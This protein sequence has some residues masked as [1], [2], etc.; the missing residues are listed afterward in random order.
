M[1]DPSSEINPLDQLAE[2]FV[3]RYRRGERPPLSEY[4]ARRPDLADEIRDLFPGLVLME[5][6]RPE[7]GEATGAFGVAGGVSKCPE[8]LGDYRILREVGR[9]GMGIVYEAEQES[10]GRHVA[11]KV[12]PPHALN[13]PQRLERFRREARAAGR[14]HHTNI[15]PVFG[16]GEWRAG[17][18][19]PPVHYYAMQF[20]QG[21]SL[22]DVLVEVR[23]L[24][25]PATP[26]AAE[27]AEDESKAKGCPASAALA[28]SL[29]DGGFAA[30]VAELVR[31]RLPEP[32]TTPAPAVSAKAASTSS[33]AHAL[34]ERSTLSERGA[35]YWRSVARIGAQAADALAYAHAQ[36]ILHR[37]IKPSNLM[38]DNQG[39]VWI[40]DFGLAKALTD[41]DDLT[42][43]GDIVGTL[44]YMAPERF[45]GRADSRGDQY[46]LALT[47]YELLTLQPAFAAS[48]RTQLIHRVMHGEPARP[49]SLDRSIPR[50]LE[51]IVLK[52]ADKDPERRYQSAAEMADDLRR[53]A[54]D[55]PIRARRAGYGER[56]WRW[57][58]RNPLPAGLAA[59]VTISLL[60]GSIVSSWLAVRAIESAEV[61]DAKAREAGDEAKRANDEKERADTKAKEEAK[62]RADEAVARKK[63]DDALRE[64][65][66]SLALLN[67]R[68][69]LHSYEQHN[70]HEARDR[71]AVIPAELRGWEWRYLRRLCDGGL[72]TLVG[73][74]NGIQQVVYSPDGRFLA[75]TSSAEV[76]VWNARTGQELYTLQGNERP[77]SPVTFR[78]DGLRLAA[79]C[80]DGSLR[81]WDAATGR[82]ALAFVVAAGIQ[83]EPAVS[84]DGRRIAAGCLDKA[85]RVWDA[86]TGKQEFVLK[87]HEQ[88]L[89]GLAFS[90]NGQELLSRAGIPAKFSLSNWPEA[91]SAIDFRGYPRPGELKLW[92]LRTSK[93]VISIANPQRPPLGAFT[94]DGRHLITVDHARTVTVW[95]VNSGQVVKRQKL[96]YGPD[97][98]FMGFSPDRRLLMSQNNQGQLIVWDIAAGQAI[99][100]L[101]GHTE[102]IHC[103]AFSPDSMYFATGSS[104]RT[105]RLWDLRSEKEFLTLHGHTNSIGSLAFSPD[106]QQLASG[107]GDST[108]KVWDA[109][110]QPGRYH[111]GGDYWAADSAISPDGHRLM[112]GGGSGSSGVRLLDAREGRTVFSANRQYTFPSG[113]AYS[114]DGFYVASTS[115]SEAV[116]WDTRTGREF[117][118]FQHPAD[119]FPIIGSLQT[120]NGP[121]VTEVPK[122]VH[123]VAFS[124]DGK[125]LASG[126]DTWVAKG[127][128][129]GEI[130]VWDLA[131]G[132]QLFILLG[133]N[134]VERLA[135]SPDGKYLA[136][137]GGDVWNLATRNK[138]FTMPWQDCVAFSPDGRWL[139]SGRKFERAVTLWDARTGQKVWTSHGHL[140]IGAGVA[141]SPD[142]LRLFSAGPALA[143]IDG[144][145]TV[146]DVHTGDELLSFPMKGNSAPYHAPVS[147]TRD[148]RAIALGQYI[149]EAPKV[150]EPLVV[151]LHSDPVTGIAFSADGARLAIGTNNG[152]VGVYD[153]RTGEK[154]VAWGV[155][156]KAVRW[157]A[158]SP[159]GTLLA[160]SSWDI[161]VRIWDSQT[162]KELRT[163]PTHGC[164]AF[165]R[166]GARL[167]CISGGRALIWDVASGRELKTFK[168]PPEPPVIRVAFS[169]DGRRLVAVLL[170]GQAAAWNLQTGQQLPGTPDGSDL[171]PDPYFSPDGKR[172]ARPD[173]GR[174]VIHDLKEPDAD[175][176]AW[177]HSRTTFDPGWHDH[178]ATAIY[179]KTTGWYGSMLWHLDRLLAEQPDDP[180]LRERRGN[181]LAELGRW[182]EARADFGFVVRKT[183]D[184]MGAWRSLALAHLGEGKT[185]AFQETCGQLKA[186]FGRPPWSSQLGLAFT[187]APGNVLNKLVL[188]A[189]IR[190]N[191][192][193]TSYS[194]AEILR[195]CMLRPG[196][197][198][199]P[200]AL[201]AFLQPHQNLERGAVLCRA[202][203]HADAARLLAEHNKKRNPDRDWA[204]AELYLAIAEQAQGHTEEATRALE[205]AAKWIDSPNGK[206][207]RWDTRVELQT[208]RHEAETLLHDEPKTPKK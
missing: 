144:G 1:S 173:G 86:K 175:E 101:A 191:L 23:R 128:R 36:G 73:H 49:R 9:G 189:S 107:S 115:G 140:G 203:K 41:G 204:L 58:R 114:P 106:G 194:Q 123:C 6:I 161:T 61:A 53:F 153:V 82:V 93:A 206:A 146:L 184:N 148:G 202:G 28:R 124:P 78:P 160:S 156:R 110:N 12:L 181:A 133:G 199:D 22:S 51:T 131:T 67:F 186:R 8:H 151:N 64:T 21:Q 32:V 98:Y 183:P 42:R 205:K 163:F 200:A 159:D 44:R 109:R 121:V 2:E 99:Q 143:G 134:M 68:Q 92:D 10:L 39:T 139:A 95:D 117:R 119:K 45:Q 177:R 30:P 185:K 89:L 172:L 26:P 4:V 79:G 118:R 122:W 100:T 179:G 90:P 125:W 165:S 180:S 198:A 104:D 7:T 85:V 102:L 129:S 164:I 74:T 187:A 29:L 108:V 59:A 192:D 145:L 65:R 69:A 33:T 72:F 152:R 54:E 19:S 162:G 157:L 138:L 150:P 190:Q 66:H 182:S 103:A 35:P 112:L 111:L 52:A 20:I 71:L 136:S 56:L 174:L 77:A 167:A 208:L 96:E 132:R 5:G 50:D 46:A 81:V 25:Q 166:D 207:Q 113:V 169:A 154:K 126:S 31:V 170:G 70:F 105:I 3:D 18:G 37:D 40:T 47:L 80:H 76:K 127:K 75:S 87:G 130:V 27:P 176:L 17:D 193:S 197:V 83:T 168:V 196:T 155:Q 24:R 48:D 94:P 141:F 15:V 188:A 55:R 88:P 142:G 13:D 147:V 62:A 149:W 60:V 91:E 171:P 195:L 201:L 43:T 16:V 84:T 63:A 120:N 178:V 116:V 57:C 158:F 14:L 38:L 11:L 137:S 97:L 135:F 34:G